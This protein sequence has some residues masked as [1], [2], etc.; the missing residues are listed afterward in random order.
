[1]GVVFVS[2]APLFCSVNSKLHFFNCDYCRL[3]CPEYHN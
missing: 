3:T 2:T 1:M